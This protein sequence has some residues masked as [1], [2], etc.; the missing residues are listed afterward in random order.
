MSFHPDGRYGD[1]GSIEVEVEPKIIAPGIVLS[2]QARYVAPRV[3]RLLRTLRVTL[4]SETMEWRNTSIDYDGRIGVWH[5]SE[6]VTRVL[7][8]ELPVPLNKTWTSK[9][10]LE[11]PREP[12]AQT[13]PGYLEH[14]VEARAELDDGVP[15]V[16]RVPVTR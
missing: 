6:I 8:T 10:T 2:G 4:I 12:L 15:I 1:L 14:Y 5:R 11:I 9:Y 7:C 3:P 16:Y 13:R